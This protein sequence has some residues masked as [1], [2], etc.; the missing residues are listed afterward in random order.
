MAVVSVVSL[1]AGWPGL[2]VFSAFLLATAVI[3]KFPLAAFFS[4]SRYVLVLLALI[5]MSHGLF[6][7]GAALFNWLGISLSQAGLIAGGLVSWRLLGIILVAA[8]VMAST[9]V[10]CLAAAVCWFLK[11][12]PIVNAQRVGMQL[13]LV[14][15]FIPLILHQADV[16]RD[17]QNARCLGHLRHPVRRLRLMVIPLMRRIFLTADR[18]ALAMAAR[19]YTEPRTQPPMAMGRGDAVAALATA[20]VSISLLVF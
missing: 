3:M 20:I 1:H 13:A 9:P 5:V 2:A 16:S 6:T 11:P 14:I 7:P 4:K 18:M 8:L 15:R 17:A 12:V 19:C 10:E